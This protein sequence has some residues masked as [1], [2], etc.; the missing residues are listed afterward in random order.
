MRKI[1][2]ICL[3]CTFL[4]FLGIS[5]DTIYATDP[6]PCGKQVVYYFDSDT[7]VLTIT[8]N[9]KMQNDRL[10]KIGLNHFGSDVE[11]VIIESGVT[12]IGDGAFYDFRNLKKVYIPDTVT[13]IGASAFRNSG[14]EEVYIPSSVTEIGNAA[15][16][17]TKLKYVTV[18]SPIIG[19]GAFYKCSNLISIKFTAKNVQLGDEILA[20]CDKLENVIFENG[21]QKLPNSFVYG[22]TSLQG[23][24]IPEGV[25]SVG[26]NA[27][28]ECSSLFYI[29]FPS[30]VNSFGDAMFERCSAL[31][32]ITLPDQM[33]TIPQY[34]F[35]DCTNL[36]KVYFP[37]SLTA[38][39]SH[40]FEGCTALTVMKIPEGVEGIDALTFFGCE[41][42]IHLTLP[43]SIT[44]IGNSA[45]RGCDN[46]V[47][48]HCM[49]NFPAIERNAFTLA[50]KIVKIYYNEGTTGWDAMDGLTQETYNI[51][52][53]SWEDVSNSSGFEESNLPI[54]EKPLLP[55][56]VDT[57]A[58]VK[59][60][61]S[62]QEDKPTDSS[63]V[64]TQEKGTETKDIVETETDSST[65]SQ[66]E[67]NTSVKS[68]NDTEL[69]NVTEESQ[70]E[71][72]KSADNED[73]ENQTEKH[74]VVLWVVLGLVVAAV[75]AVV[76]IIC[77]KTRKN[78]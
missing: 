50:G 5:S 10:Y 55:A 18:S 66:I 35:K 16:A 8:G 41:N 52:I 29:D 34:T 57:Q 20:A 43:A 65:E 63:S 15:F 7:K 31:E 32:V 11:T 69:N 75:V 28:A 25:T 46:L 76:V 6:Q 42:L 22:C 51:T 27:F 72:L 24:T 44:A 40:A 9:G 45:F 61:S 4:L 14:L 47:S 68:E 59:T 13:S 39:G 70:R 67:E 2:F 71:E 54:P 37:S 77:I 1:V 38:I 53:L 60:Q 56:H 30:S 26:D 19:T 62:N 49:G 58:P 48:V 12:H 64:D 78:K 73:V 23:F 33:T 17:E 36:K 21:V 3:I 74:P